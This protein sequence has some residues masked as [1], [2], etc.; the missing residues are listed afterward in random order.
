MSIPIAKCDE[1]QL[2]SFYPP[3]LKHEILA[4]KLTKEKS[5]YCVD[6]DVMAKTPLF[7]DRYADEFSYLE[8]SLVPCTSSL[9]TDKNK[10]CRKDNSDSGTLDIQKTSL[11]GAELIVMTNHEV[12]SPDDFQRPIIPSSTLYRRPLY[13]EVSTELDLSIKTTLVSDKTEFIQY[14]QSQD[15]LCKEMAV[16]SYASMIWPGEYPDSYKM[17][18][19]VIA[20][21][22]DAQ[23]IKRETAS[24]MPFLAHFGGLIYISL[25]FCALIVAPF[26]KTQI[27]RNIM[28]TLYMYKPRSEDLPK[29]AAPAPTNDPKLKTARNV[30]QMITEQL[31]TVAEI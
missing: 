4:E 29:L 16:K 11:A 26:V 6:T 22:L 31:G 5:L 3:M 18:S 9:I 28:K 15:F 30:K 8:I 24:L 27:H 12:F 23:I 10:N 20:P 1:A 25:G 17:A 14:G 21:S 13:K 2:S 7:G 19:V